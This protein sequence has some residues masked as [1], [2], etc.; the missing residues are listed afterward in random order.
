MPYSPFQMANPP[1]SP[2][3][4]ELLAVQYARDGGNTR[5][6]RLRALLC[7]HIF[8]GFDLLGGGLIQLRLLI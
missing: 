7:G 3:P 4:N 6:L 8:A 2:R 1:F 5:P